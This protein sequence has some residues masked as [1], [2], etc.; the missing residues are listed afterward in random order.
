MKI[1][2]QDGRKP[3]SVLDKGMLAYSLG[4]FEQISINQSSFAE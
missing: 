2:V 3:V 4:M 1:G